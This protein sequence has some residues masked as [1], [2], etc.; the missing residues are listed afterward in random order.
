[1]AS[2]RSAYA[3]LEAAIPVVTPGAFL[4]LDDETLRTVGFSRQKSSYC[5]GLAAAIREGAF[6]PEDLADLSDDEAAAVLVGLR[7]IGPWTAACYLLGALSR[8]DA[9]PTGDRALQVAMGTV[10]GMDRVPTTEESDSI[11]ERW[12]PWR[13]VAA[14]MLWH[15][16]LGGDPAGPVE[17]GRGSA[18]GRVGS[19]S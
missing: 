10:L 2:A 6:R 3:R 16:Y 11:A 12:R 9:W 4:T 15:D 17:V 7:G 5:R 14:R 8:E 13:A 18:E 1:L 19:R